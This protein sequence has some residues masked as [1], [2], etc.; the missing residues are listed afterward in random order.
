MAVNVINLTP[1]KGKR[2]NKCSTPHRDRRGF[3]FSGSVRVRSLAKL[4]MLTEK[5][6]AP[7]SLLL[8]ILWMLPAEGRL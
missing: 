5:E 7:T 2:I 8:T 6:G 3:F 1:G 4:K